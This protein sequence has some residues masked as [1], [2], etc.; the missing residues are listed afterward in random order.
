MRGGNNMS[1]DLM[2]KVVFWVCVF[3]MALIIGGVI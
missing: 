3:I 2:D 1:A